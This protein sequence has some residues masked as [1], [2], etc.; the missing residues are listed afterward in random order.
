MYF[1]LFVVVVVVLGGFCLCLSLTKLSNE[2]S[3]F[4]QNLK[5]GKKIPRMVWFVMLITVWVTVVSD[6]ICSI[7]LASI[8]KRKKNAEFL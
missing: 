5:I 7:V 8:L 3:I 6:F 2:L 4:K 1:V